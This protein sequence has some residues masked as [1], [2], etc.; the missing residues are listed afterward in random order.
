MISEDAKFALGSL[1]LS[2]R[3]DEAIALVER[4]GRA[5]SHAGGLG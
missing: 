5:R 1:E 3:T 4:A 2:C